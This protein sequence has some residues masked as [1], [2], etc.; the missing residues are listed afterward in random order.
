MTNTI[1]AACDRPVTATVLCTD[2]HATLQRDLDRLLWLVEQLRNSETRQVRFSRQHGSRST[3]SPILWNERA[4]RQLHTIDT[5]VAVW[6]PRLADAVGDPVRYPNTVTALLWM[7][8]IV[9]E[10]P[11][12]SWVD[13]G[14][15][16]D[17]MASLCER[18]LPIINRP[19][20]QQYLG[21]CADARDVKSDLNGPAGP[22][23]C[24]GRVMGIGENP[25]A[26]CDTCGT[27]Y[28]AEALRLRL[29]LEL[30]ARWCTA[31]EIARLSTYLGLTM[32]REQVRKRINQWHRRGRIQ[33]SDVD[34]D[35]PRF[36]FR[37]VRLLLEENDDKAAQTA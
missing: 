22:D 26:R 3:E 23:G 15:F 34:V 2:C 11:P 19:P 16:A 9:R 8:T 32:N 37:E 27:D 1:C 25:T 5:I 29:L 18:C 36:L 30:D 28:D 10:R 33:T 20:A 4:S 17:A 35:E 7:S 6:Q 24:P 31:A 13:S 12:H 14:H 21:D